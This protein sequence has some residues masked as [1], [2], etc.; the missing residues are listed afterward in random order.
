MA[1]K[2]G[3]KSKKH[4][5]GVHPNMIRLV[6]ACIKETPIDFTILKSGGLRTASQQMAIFKRG[7]SKMNGR[8]RKSMHQKQ[9]SGFGEA[10][11]LIPWVAGSPRWEWPL[12]Y[13]IAATMA[14]LSKEMKIDIRWGGVW[15]KELDDFIG[16]DYTQEVLTQKIKTEV[17]AYCVRHPGPDFIDGP[18]YELH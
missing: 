1:Y 5:E 4:L 8:D 15:D 3:D 11:D 14:R 16:T 6:E 10:V 12:I 18:H 7:A 2:L 9:A 17:R 13:P